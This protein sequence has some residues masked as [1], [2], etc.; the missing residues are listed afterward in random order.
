MSLTS[1]QVSFTKRHHARLH[2]RKS[3]PNS[4][5]KY[6]SPTLSVHRLNL[7]DLSLHRDRHINKF[8]SVLNLRDLDVF[9]LVPL[10]VFGL[11]PA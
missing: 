8:V 5:V 10:G 3:K 6:P 7:R 11:A 9:G 1:F 4:L 2:D